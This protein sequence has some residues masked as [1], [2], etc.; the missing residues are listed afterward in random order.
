VALYPLLIHVNLQLAKQRKQRRPIESAVHG[1]ERGHRA[2]LR[3]ASATS[4][5][6]PPNSSS[7]SAAAVET[8]LAD[9]ESGN[10]TQA[11][12]RGGHRPGHGSRRLVLMHAYRNARLLEGVS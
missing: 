3:L 9:V 1:G 10:G 4:P 8:P 5:V 6:T 2:S 11:P 7:A 12:R